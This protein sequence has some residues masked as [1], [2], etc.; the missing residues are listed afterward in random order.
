MNIRKEYIKRLIEGVRH[1][2]EEDPLTIEGV[3]LMGEGTLPARWTDA[4][5]LCSVIEIDVLNINRQDNNP[6][7]NSIIPQIR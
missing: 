4:E 5:L 7:H 1:Q 2:I 3:D 6:V